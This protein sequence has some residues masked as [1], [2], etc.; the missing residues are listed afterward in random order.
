M[1]PLTQLLLLGV[2]LWTRLSSCLGAGLAVP[3]IKSKGLLTVSGMK[4]SAAGP[5]GS[6]V[7][8]GQG[9]EYSIGA[10]AAGSF[11]VSHGD[12]PLLSLVDNTLHANTAKIEA[13][14]LNVAGDV[15]I[16]GV[17]QW[18]L[19]ATEDF[20]A[21]GVGWSKGDVSQC[22][23]VSMLGGYCKFAQGEVTKTFA[24]LP[25]HK[26]LR[27]VANY[28]FID[29]WIG[30][31]GYMKLNIGQ[32]GGQVPVWSEQHTQTE[33]KHGLSLCGQEDTPEGKF[34]VPIDVSVPHHEESVEVTVGSTMDSSDPCD[35]SWGISGFEIW[36]RN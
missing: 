11:V 12:S 17:A 27:V 19:V 36:T 3:A 9:A 24:G 18:R 13:Q 21:Q 22:G 31:S 29:R 33:A 14:S 1:K 15:T 4:V 26:Q 20:A 28:H 8:F 2:V 30:E 32:G 16:G 23:G 7:H 25:P 10:D 6:M 34:S 5:Q 35:E